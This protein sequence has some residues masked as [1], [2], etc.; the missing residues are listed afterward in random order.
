MSRDSNP[1]ENA[2]IGAVDREI[3]MMG[4]RAEQLRFAGRRAC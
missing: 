4:K 3:K 2:A 1:T